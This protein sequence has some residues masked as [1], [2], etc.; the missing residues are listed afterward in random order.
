MTVVARRGPTAVETVEI[1]A[2]VFDG[3]Q[4]KSCGFPG[5]IAKCSDS[6]QL[7]LPGS[8]ADSQDSGRILSAV[9]HWR[10]TRRRVRMHTTALSDDRTQVQGVRERAVTGS[11]GRRDCMS[12]EPTGA[13]GEPLRTS[14]RQVPHTI[15]GGEDRRGSAK[16]DDVLP[17]GSPP[18]SERQDAEGG[19]ASGCR[20]PGTRPQDGSGSHAARRRPGREL[21]PP[22]VC[23]GGAAPDLFVDK[24]L[25]QVLDVHVPN[26]Q[27]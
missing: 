9:A 25:A 22:P 24:L 5:P 20:R 23:P 11:A 27:Y 4:R 19:P 13:V 16:G 18:P 6:Y 3:H 17:H 1:L 12:T 10:T 14:D 7:Y 8:P 26:Y 21:S 2:W 15:G